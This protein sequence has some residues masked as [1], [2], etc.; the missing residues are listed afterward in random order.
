M[1]IIA[2][3][4]DSHY[5]YDIPICVF[6]LITIFIIRKR[7]YLIPVHY[8]LYSIFL[9]IHCLGMLDFYSLHPLNIEYDYWVHG[10]FGFVSILM[11]IHLLKMYSHSLSVLMINF[12][13]I[14]IILG[15]SAIH[16]LYEFAGALLLG[17]GDGVLFIGAGDL[18]PWDTQKDMLNN[19]I[20]GIAGLIFS[21]IST[22]K[23]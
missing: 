9:F 14:I 15:I 13:A 6:L 23:H 4:M 2:L 17:E 1:E 21:V 16:E 8:F 5:K 3:R 10:Y 22:K 7:I 19:L 11:I 12:M 18:D 20:G